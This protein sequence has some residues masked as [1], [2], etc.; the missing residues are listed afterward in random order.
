M[1]MG[2]QEDCTQQVS[3]DAT[4]GGQFFPRLDLHPF[5]RE[6]KRFVGGYKF[7][8]GLLTNLVVLIGRG[9]P[10]ARFDLTCLIR[11]LSFSCDSLPFFGQAHCK[12][13]NPPRIG[14]N[15]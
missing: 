12:T 6:L 1:I 10:N 14:E 9:N 8:Y 11:T 13:V 3:L 2:L 7:A 5:Q 4:A 15:F